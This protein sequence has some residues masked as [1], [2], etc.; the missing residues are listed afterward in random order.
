MRR[1]DKIN[2]AKVMISFSLVLIFSGVA[3]D[4]EKNAKAINPIKETYVLSN[5]SDTS[6][7]ISITTIDGTK[8]TPTNDDKEN[9]DDQSLSKENTNQSNDD[10]KNNQEV[11]DQNNALRNTIQNNYG[12]TIKYGIETDGY[13]VGGLSTTSL[14]DKNSIAEALNNLNGSLAVYPSNFFQEMRN[15]GYP[16]TIYLIKRYSANNVTGITDST[17]NN[18]VI[19][20]AT[21]YSFG[22]SFHHEIYHYIERYIYARGGKYTTWNNLNPIGFNYGNQ[23]SAL[24]FD[25]TDSP[26]AYF[27]NNYA[28]TDAAEDRASTFEYMTAP[29]KNTCLES[30][31]HIWLKAKYMCEQIDAVFNS[32]NSHTKEYWE[33]YVY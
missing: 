16:L 20:I 33:R 19:S 24:S 5:P 4:L 32:V 3:F 17:N 9:D 22:E 28:Q 15:G 1:T 23:N 11:I 18:I 6:D 2:L 12:I 30:G 21:D 7:T 13:S 10:K 26:D 14:T 29:S 8:I 27:V 31:R 25:I